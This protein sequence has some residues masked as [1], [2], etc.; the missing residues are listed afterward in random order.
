MDAQ[1]P[2]GSYEQEQ[3]LAMKIKTKV[4]EVIRQEKRLGGELDQ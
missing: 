4:L 2:E 3:E 1:T